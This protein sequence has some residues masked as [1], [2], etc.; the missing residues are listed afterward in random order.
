MKFF[1]VCGVR[2]VEFFHLIYHF[3]YFFLLFIAG[4]QKL[5]SPP[6]MTIPVKLVDE[7]LQWC[8]NAL[9]VIYI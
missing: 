2:V 5:L 6:E 9:E 1:C 8:D 3:I 7:S 4:D